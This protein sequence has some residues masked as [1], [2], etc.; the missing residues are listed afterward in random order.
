MPSY[1]YIKIDFLIIK[2]GWNQQK[3]ILKFYQKILDIIQTILYDIVVPRKEVHK[4]AEWQQL[5]RVVT[6]SKKKLA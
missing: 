2:V 1:G 6:F 5:E 3:E 4:K